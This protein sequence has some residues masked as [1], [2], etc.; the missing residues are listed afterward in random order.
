MLRYRPQLAGETKWQRRDWVF[1]VETSADRD[2]LLARVQIDILRALLHHAEPEDTFTVLTAGT[3]VKA[4][5]E[6]PQPVTD[7]NVQAAVQFLENAHLIG[8]LDLGQALGAAEPFLKAGNN[9]YLIHLG[10]G[11]AA[12]GE[13]RA[14]VLAKHLPEGTRYVGVGVGRRWARN[15]MKATAERTGGYFTQINPDEPVGWRSF[16]LFATLNTPR[17][18]NVKVTDNDE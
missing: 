14:E 3:R 12:M 8:A 13:R 18:L 16:E 5:T 4:F 6:K 10:S 1:L 15:F 11:I 7:A 9:P 17:L 2:P